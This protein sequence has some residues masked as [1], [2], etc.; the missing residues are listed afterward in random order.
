MPATDPVGELRSWAAD[1]LLV[2]PG[3]PEAGEAMALPD[4]ACDFLRAGWPAHESALGVA[5]KNG[6]SAIAA[7]L[8][9]GVVVGPLRVQGWR[10]AIASVSKEKASEL[11]AQVEA[12]ATASGLE[13]VQT[14]RSP[15]PGLV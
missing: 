11:R 3:H 1:N 7:I 5:R 13:N 14:S 10:G 15:Y 8:A 4:F 12:I 9:L 6:K 2:P